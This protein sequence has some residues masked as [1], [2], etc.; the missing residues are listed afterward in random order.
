[1]K[2]KSENKKVVIKDKEESESDEEISSEEDSEEESEEDDE[3]ETDL[4]DEEDD[5]DTLDSEKD[6]L[7]SNKSD[8]NDNKKNDDEDDEYIDSNKN[9]LI[10]L[11]I[12]EIDNDTLTET[13]DRITK[14]YFTHYEITRILMV[15]TRQLELGAKPMIKIDENIILSPKEIARLELKKKSTPFIIERPIPLRK[16]EFWKVSELNF[17]DEFN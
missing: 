10:D 4:D 11:N 5:D 16:S 1:M 17:L 15:R 7:E 3:E 8:D 2:G 14:P 12:I 13:N 6:E 9:E